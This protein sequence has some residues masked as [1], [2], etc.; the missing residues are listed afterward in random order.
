MKYIIVFIII[1]TLVLTVVIVTQTTSCGRRSYFEGETTS[2]KKS[3]T[4]MCGS[5]A[6]LTEIQRKLRFEC[7]RDRFCNGDEKCTN[8]IC[9][10]P[11]YATPTLSFVQT[12]TK[13]CGDP[14]S[15]KRDSWNACCYAEVCNYDIN[16]YKRNCSETLPPSHAA[17]EN[18]V[19]PS[20]QR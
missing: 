3:L 18:I 15:Q 5:N 10:V 17:S 19:G 8:K 6:L 4:E 20:E 7:C 1:I 12:T 13:M 16:C 2:S 14:C 9:Y 11:T